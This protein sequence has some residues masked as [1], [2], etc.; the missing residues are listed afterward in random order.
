MEQTLMNSRKERNRRVGV[1][2]AAVALG[3]AVY[4]FLVIKNRGHIA[5]PSNMTK[6]EKIFRGL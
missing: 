6:A 4:S 3:L 1:G 5:E 2:L